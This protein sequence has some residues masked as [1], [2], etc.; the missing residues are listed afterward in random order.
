VTA[1]SVPAAAPGDA[2]IDLVP[3]FLAFWEKQIAIEKA[4]GR[5]ASMLR[6]LLLFHA[7]DLVRNILILVVCAAAW[8]TNPAI[9]IR[10]LIEYVESGRNDDINTGLPLVAAIVVT[11]AVR[12]LT[13]QQFVGPW[14]ATMIVHGVEVCVCVCVC[15]SVCV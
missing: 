6:S 9:W 7:A 13:I 2:P 15:V 1:E 12:S 4:G 5:P 11:E 10:L 8:I 14:L 3:K